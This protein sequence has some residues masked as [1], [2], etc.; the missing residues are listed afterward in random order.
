MDDD[1]Q[2]KLQQRLIGK[3]KELFQ[4]DQPDLDFGFYRIMHAKAGQVTAFLETDLPAIIREAFA[5][6]DSD[7]QEVLLKKARDTAIGA[8]GQEA[9]GTDGKL[10]EAFKG[11]PAGKTYL[12]ALEKTRRAKD[13][14]NA[15]ADVY[16]HL[17]RFFER[18]YDGGDF[19]SLR[20]YARETTDRAASYAIP[21]SGEEVKLHWAN[22]D[23]Y[24]TRYRHKLRIFM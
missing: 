22:A 18:Y 7:D 3:L 24:Y 21:Y 19:M 5:D 17:Y 13:R 14:G 15:E 9:I 1:R 20:Y 6:G 8:L 10:N 4:L 23:Q 11:T 16:D 2:E 12:E